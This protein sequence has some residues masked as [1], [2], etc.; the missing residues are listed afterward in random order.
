MKRAKAV[1]G[2]SALAMTGLLLTACTQT[3]IEEAGRAAIRKDAE[4]VMETV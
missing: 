1:T 2:C 4:A 3:G